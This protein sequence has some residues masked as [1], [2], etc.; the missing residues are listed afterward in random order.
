MSRDP[1]WKIFAALIL[2]GGFGAAPVAAADQYPSKPVTIVVPYQPGGG[3]DLAVRSIANVLREQTGQPFIVENRSGASGKVGSRY[4]LGMPPDGYT[5]LADTDTFVTNAALE[6]RD[7]QVGR[8]MVAGASLTAV[9]L[10]IAVNPS[11]PVHSIAELVDYLKTTPNQQ[12][13]SS[14]G[15]GTVMHLVAELFKQVAKVQM[16]H[17]P[18]AGCAHA[19][20]DGLGGHVPILFNTAANVVPYAQAGKLRI[21][22][23]TRP[24]SLEGIQEK[25]PVL[26]ELP[27]F[28]NVRG[29]SWAGIFLPVG[30]PA[31]LVDRINDLVSKAKQD[32]RVVSQFQRATQTSLEMSPKEFT[33]FA[34]AELVRWRKVVETANITAE[35]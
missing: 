19:I 32:S 16:A 11:L 22:A 25:V 10:V 15:I 31:T 17:V 29:Q 24:A 30:A 7:L 9:P 21:L 4:V 26:Y 28:E 33:E 18:Y 3:L 8:D 20:N 13:Y 27:G 35:N 2:L 23:V 12:S 14:C 34:N 1:Y 6:R 5:L